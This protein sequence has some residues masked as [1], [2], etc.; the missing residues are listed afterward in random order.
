MDILIITLKV[1]F[2]ENL[3][4]SILKLSSTTGV[5]IAIVI[6]VVTYVMVYIDIE[7]VVL[8]FQSAL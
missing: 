8:S 7:E 3:S 2:R 1:G 4:G 6:T 5:I